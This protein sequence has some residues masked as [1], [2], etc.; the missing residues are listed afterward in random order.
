MPEEQKRYYQ[1][2]RY[3]NDGEE[4]WIRWPQKGPGVG[5]RCKVAVAMGRTARVVNEAMGVDRLY[6]IDDLLVPPDDPRAHG[7]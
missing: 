5:L 7:G 2:P 3:V 1:P 4:V 6:D